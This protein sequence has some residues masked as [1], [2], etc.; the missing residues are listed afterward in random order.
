MARPG[1][2]FEI[3]RR[4]G[5]EPARQF[6][7]ER[8]RERGL[9]IVGRDLG[10][11]RA[12][13]NKGREPVLSACRQSGV[14]QIRPFIALGAAQKGDAVAPL[15]LRLRPRQARHAEPADAARE[16]PRILLR[17]LDRP[18]VLGEP[19]RAETPVGAPPQAG[20]RRIKNGFV[21]SLDAVG[22]DRLDLLG[23]ERASREDAR[24]RRPAGDFGDGEKWRAR[25]RVF[26]GHGRGAAI[27]HQELAA[28]AARFGDAIGKSQRDQR[29]VG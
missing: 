7:G 28:R 6:V 2:R 26:D 29:A 10:E 18:I 12:S 25:Q 21:A 17:R 15:H 3:R 4:F 14:G 19:Y 9:E 23:G 20:A 22:G 13:R 11:R 5:V 1:G 8:L 27:R 16:R 24:L